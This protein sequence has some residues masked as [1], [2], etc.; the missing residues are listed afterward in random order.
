MAE[1]QKKRVTFYIDGFN[2]YY[3]IKRS[4]NSNI[5]RKWGNA[6]WIDLVKLCEGFISPD[7]EIEK[8]I[9][10]TASPLSTNKSARQSAFLNAYK[11]GI[12]TYVTQ[13]CK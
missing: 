12:C 1:K 10:F 5:D 13:K 7:E 6:Y 8:V 2:F 9:Y 3:G 11:L 4:S